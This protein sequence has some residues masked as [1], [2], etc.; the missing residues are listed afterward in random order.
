MGHV[1]TILESL[2]AHIEHP[3][4]RPGA[5]VLPSKWIPVL[6]PIYSLPL[7]PEPIQLGA[8]EGGEARIGVRAPL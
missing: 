6:T 1:H 3:E 7:E 4:D 5:F 2:K 8:R